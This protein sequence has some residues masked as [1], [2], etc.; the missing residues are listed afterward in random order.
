MDTFQFTNK[1]TVLSE[2]RYQLADKTELPL[3]EF[4]KLNTIPHIV[5]GFSTRKG[6]VSRGIFES[7]NLSFMRNDDPVCV[8]KNFD[9]VAEALNITVEDMVTSDQMHTNHV[10]RVY[11]KD[12]GCGITHKRSFSDVDGMITNEKN[13]CLCA[14]FA[15][16]V[17][18][19][20]VDPVHQAI[21]LAHSGWRGTIQRIGKEILKQMN[22]E[23]GTEPQEVICAIGPSICQSCYEVSEELA[24]QFAVEFCQTEDLQTVPA[25]LLYPGKKEG[26]YQL[27]LW[28]ANERVLREAGIQ[29][30][31]LAVTN[32]C[33]C[34]NSSLLF[35]HRATAGKR[36]NLAAFLMLG[37]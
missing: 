25:S 37:K 1:K 9:R 13:V 21:G 18:L 33:T 15:D 4:A 11:K 36:G 19:Y 14:F 28:N 12:G 17:P 35:S 27:N 31:N 29:K 22:E 24:I 16:C 30:E 23:F 8:R 5:H 20:F 34:C 26:K 7:L 6:G 2:H 32:L 3:L 10:R